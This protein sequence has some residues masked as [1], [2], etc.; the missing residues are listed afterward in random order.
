MGAALRLR[1]A[2]PLQAVEQH[3]EIGALNAERRGDVRLLQSGRMTEQH[4][5]AVLRRPQ[6]ELGEIGD[7]VVEHGKLRA[8]QRI[9]DHACERTHVDRRGARIVLRWLPAQLGCAALFLSALE[10]MLGDVISCSLIL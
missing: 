9:A 1:Q 8:P 3:H 2:A 6:L 4:Q 5:H 7:D 10:L